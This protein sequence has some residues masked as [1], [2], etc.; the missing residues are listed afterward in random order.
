[1]RKSGIILAI[2]LLACGM[3]VNFS[4]LGLPRAWNI[5]A[6]SQAFAGDDLVPPEATGF[7]GTLLAEAT[8]VNAGDP[9]IKSGWGGFLK[10]KVIKVLGYEPRN[11]VKMPPDALTAIWK[12][13]T[14]NVGAAVNIGNAPIAKSWP[15]INGGDMLIVTCYQN[16]GHL[17]QT[18]VIAY[19]PGEDEPNCYAFMKK[20]DD[21]KKI[22]ITL[23]KLIDLKSITK[24]VTLAME[25]NADGKMVAKADLLAALDG[26]KEKDVVMVQLDHDVLTSIKAYEPP[27]KGT[28]VKLTTQKVGD[29]DLPA[30]ELKDDNGTDQT[31]P[32]SAKN[33]INLT[34][35]AHSLKADTAIL[36]RTES[37]DKG[38]WLTDIH[39]PS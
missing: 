8:G 20:L 16:E 14:A 28:F 13:K 4:E 37:D 34:H 10:I 7:N 36:Y 39:L 17:R 5:F 1:M 23:R 19:R 33:A 30:V 3:I 21:G 18:R 6:P 38:E 31:L 25:K 26:F 15:E 12:G 24:T 9:A 22:S 35:L 32:L 11:G 29:K 27:K 2:T